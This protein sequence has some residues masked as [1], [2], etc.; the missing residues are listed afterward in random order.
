MMAMVLGIQKKLPVIT[1]AAFSLS[2]T[3]T[4]RVVNRK[5]NPKDANVK[6]A[7]RFMPHPLFWKVGE[8]QLAKVQSLANFQKTNKQHRHIYEL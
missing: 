3:V 5:E 1:W 2:P 6:I 4:N 7:Y 8:F